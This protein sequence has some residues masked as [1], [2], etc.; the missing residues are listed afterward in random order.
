MVESRRLPR[1]PLHNPA[2]YD[3]TLGETGDNGD[4]ENG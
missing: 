1:G 4:D 2:R 3:G